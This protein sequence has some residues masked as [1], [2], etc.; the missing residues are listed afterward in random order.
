MEPN[1]GV[2]L[3]KAKREVTRLERELAKQT[4][5]KKRRST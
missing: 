2:D 5:T 1:L 3:A 4:L